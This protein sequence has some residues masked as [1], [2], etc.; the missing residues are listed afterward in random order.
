MLAPGTCSRTSGRWTIDLEVG[1]GCL[2][3]PQNEIRSK[4][5]LLS[6]SA[7]C[8]Q[9]KRLITLTTNTKLAVNEIPVRAEVHE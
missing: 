2:S 4:I 8:Y 6:T 5:N 3:L 9:A 7:Q 1:K